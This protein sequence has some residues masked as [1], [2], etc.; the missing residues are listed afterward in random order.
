M[1]SNSEKLEILTRNLEDLPAAAADFLNVLKGRRHIA[2]IAPM[3][4]G[5]TTFVA[6]LCR[7]LGVEDDVTSPTFSIVNQYQCNNGEMVFHFDFYRIETTE[8]ALDLG[9]DEYFDSDAL[10]LM[11]WPENVDPFLPADTTYVNIEILPDDSRK[12]SL[13]KHV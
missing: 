7:Q 11:E 12:I 3:G 9:L 13:S 4:A 6:E 8:E 10:C 2:F 5:K 1:D